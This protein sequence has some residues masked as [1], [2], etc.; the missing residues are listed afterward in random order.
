MPTAKHT[1]ED[2]EKLAKAL[3][4]MWQARPVPKGTAD[5]VMERVKSR[6]AQERGPGT[7]EA[8]AAD[9]RLDD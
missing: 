7:E 9:R 8:P 4:E 2:E 1:A 5:L 6:I 3:R